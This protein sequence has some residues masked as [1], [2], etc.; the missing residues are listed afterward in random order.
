MLFVTF[1]WVPIRQT[2]NKLAIFRIA[3]LNFF[4]SGKDSALK[5]FCAIFLSVLLAACT[6]V[7]TNPRRV[8][9]PEEGQVIVG[10]K[11]GDEV[12]IFMKN[13]YTQH[14]FLVTDVDEF[15]LHS[16]QRSFPYR[17]IEWVVVRKLRLV[18]VL[19]LR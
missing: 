18:P 19:P 6:T 12:D 15:G 10:V 13:D 17:D 9:L 2:R 4:S 16:D 8:Y 11:K 7:H 14:S 3:T 1:S 5:V